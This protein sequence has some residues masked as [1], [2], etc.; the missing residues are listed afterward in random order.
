[1]WSL[2]APVDTSKTSADHPKKR[3]RESSSHLSPDGQP[4]YF[5]TSCEHSF[6]HLPI[7]A[8]QRRGTHIFPHNLSFR[9][10][11]WLEHEIPED[12]EGYDVVIA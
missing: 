12:K 8:A 3:K 2:Q 9:T 6:G 7:P 11:N 1:M 4:N 5:P 10:A